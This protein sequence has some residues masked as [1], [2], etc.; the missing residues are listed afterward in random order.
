M[1][2]KKRVIGFCHAAAAR[3]K[4]KLNEKSKRFW[5]TL[6][7]EMRRMHADVVYFRCDEVEALGYFQLSNMR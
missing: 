1:V 5:M 6:M 3:Y 2:K 7:W 4:W